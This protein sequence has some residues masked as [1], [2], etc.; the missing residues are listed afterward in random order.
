MAWN[1]VS[2]CTRESVSVVCKH[3]CMCV[4]VLSGKHLS[5]HVCVHV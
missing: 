4:H 2:V 5:V 1:S 3:V